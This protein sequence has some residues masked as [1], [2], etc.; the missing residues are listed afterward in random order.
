[1]YMLHVCVHALLDSNYKKPVPTQETGF[2]SMIA[3]YIFTAIP[4]PA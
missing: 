4:A 2:Y 1:M 3:Y